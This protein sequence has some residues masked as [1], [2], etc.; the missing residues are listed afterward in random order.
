MS[1]TTTHADGATLDRLPRPIARLLGAARVTGAVLLVATGPLAAWGTFV[2]ARGM[3]GECGGDAPPCPPGSMSAILALM[4]AWF[5]LLPVGALLV[6]R[7][8]APILAGVAVLTGGMA[9]GVL[10]SRYIADPV[11][12]ATRTTWWFVAILGTASVVCAAA[13]IVLAGRGRHAAIADDRAS[14]RP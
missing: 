5:V 8:P 7:R 1:D 6:G 2:P 3:P 11:T 14:C 4:V 10:A 9:A 12:H 13:A